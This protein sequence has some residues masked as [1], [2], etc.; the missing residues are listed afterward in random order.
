MLD[1]WRHWAIALALLIILAVA[2]DAF[3]QGATDRPSRLS[4][5]DRVLRHFD[6]EDAE[7]FNTTF[8]ADF[9]RYDASGQ[10]FPPF[11]SMTLSNDHAAS[12]RWSLGFTLA[13]GS[14]SA[15]VPTGVLP[16]L[17]HADYVVSAKVKTAG[18]KNAR[19]RLVAWLHDVNGKPIAESRAES[20]PVLA[21]DG[22]ESLSVEVRGD[23]PHARD[24]VVELQLLQSRQFQTQPD[25]VD[26]PMLE[27]LTGK[28]WFD[29]VIISHLPR[30]SITMNQPE[31]VVIQPAKPTLSV[32]LSELCPDPLMATL[33]VLNLDGQTA[34]QTTFPAPRGRH[35]T[36]LDMPLDRCGWYR[37]VLDITTGQTLIRR[38]WLDFVVLPPRH[39]AAAN[40]VDHRFAVV[41]PQTSD[42]GMEHIPHL[43]EALDAGCAIV[44]AWDRGLTLKN[45]HDHLS[46]LRQ[47]IERLIFQRVD[48]I[49]AIDC[50]PDELTRTLN[51]E[52]SQV[53]EMVQR[54][55][56]EWRPYLDDLLVNFG[57]E[58]NRWQIGPCGAPEAP[59]SPQLVQAVDAAARS[60]ADYVPRPRIFVPWSAERE[61]AQSSAVQ[62]FTIG[63]PYSVSYEGLAEYASR[64][65]A[66]G[67][68]VL[69][70]FEALPR[71]QYTPRRRVTDLML[72]AL[73]GWR[74]GIPR[75][76]INAP[77]SYTDERHIQAMPDPAFP[78]WRS[79]AQHLHGRTFA[80]VLP[81]D[82]GSHCW[83]LQGQST[84]DAALIVWCE[85]QSSSRSAVLHSQL[86]SGPVTV[87]DAFGNQSI[88]EPVG[89]Y[90]TIN[91]DEMPT[92]VE[93]I[94]RELVQFRGEF[95]IEPGFIPAVA[96]VHEHQ[97]VLRNPWGIAVSGSLRVTGDGEWQLSPAVQEFSIQPH[98][99]VR[100]PLS[101]IPERNILAGHK[102]LEADIALNADRAYKLQVKTDVEVGLKN[103]DLVS[104]WAI[105][106]NVQTGQDDL[107]ISN[108]VTNKGGTTI[109][110]DV[111][112]LAEGV[113]QN[114]RTIARL[115]AGSTAVRAFRIPNGAAILGGKQVRVGVAER[116]GVT[117]L[118]RVLAISPQ[119]TANAEPK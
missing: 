99:E 70:V 6:F 119:Q 118:N 96:A 24:L 84:D 62:S 106:H 46:P 79:L 41:L 21:N 10:G 26:T 7:H 81:L 75:L 85:G 44:P 1:S 100:L 76:G 102:P 74:A 2:G 73:H 111:F 78:A 72:R 108:V 28:A 60:L 104:T 12:G 107:V 97:I 110:L 17:P 25:N 40:E 105:A 3:A 48:L 29:E 66:A 16:V 101:I 22:W 11:G 27:D 77:W 47:L 34:W 33:R 30:L 15:R 71:E 38:R 19:V 42:A 89:G 35:S 98:G 92:F 61:L 93:G 32:G 39:R 115:G 109:N 49:M 112:L 9:Y 50:V 31:N 57:L 13:G 51:L 36:D 64:W 63:V 55:P 52:P 20:R 4:T 58:T 67:D 53:L 113:S 91:L 56:R 103:I 94:N 117:R 116:D 69:A 87:I 114:R 37:A 95:A 80:G 8:P 83:I 88:V 90:H 23:F 5:L 82:D 68:D 43:L 86:A 14:M 65:S 54:D 59:L 45:A 18:L